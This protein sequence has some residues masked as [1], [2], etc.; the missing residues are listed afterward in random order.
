VAELDKI[1][2][3]MD[4]LDKQDITLD[5][6]LRDHASAQIDA[7]VARVRTMQAEALAVETSTSGGPN[8]RS[9][10]GTVTNNFNQ[11]LSRSDVVNITTEQGRLFNRN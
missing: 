11:N 4:L 2:V 1:G 9:G 8:S 7:L 3:R 5:V 6:Y 10:G